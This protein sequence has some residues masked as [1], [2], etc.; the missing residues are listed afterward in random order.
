MPQIELSNHTQNSEI[1]KVIIEFNDKTNDSHVFWHDRREQ[2]LPTTDFLKT[3]HSAFSHPLLKQKIFFDGKECFFYYQDINSLKHF[4]AAIYASF[5]FHAPTIN[6]V[7]IIAKNY[8]RSS[9]QKT[10]PYALRNKGHTSLSIYQF[11]DLIKG[12]ELGSNYHFYEKLCFA[13]TIYID[14]LPESNIDTNL[15]KSEIDLPSLTETLIEPIY[16]NYISDTIGHGAFANKRIKQGEII[17]FYAGKL[18]SQKKAPRSCFKFGLSEKN[19]KLV[20]DAASNGNLSRFI[21]HAPLEK[22]LPTLKLN[23]KTKK[24]VALANV[25]VEYQC[26]FGLDI[27]CFSALRDIDKNEQLFID[28]G[29]KYWKNVEPLYFNRKNQVIN[30]KGEKQKNAQTISKSMLRHMAHLGV[31]EANKQ[32]YLKPVIAFVFFM[33]IFLLINLY[34]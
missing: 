19:F 22:K 31:Q 9:P 24:T 7:K 1:K 23:K 18:V 17:S 27:I 8:Q 34:L 12:H 4:A 28:Y 33:F 14:D 30:K 6:K 26:Y 10:I 16:I 25:G 32:L 5:I 21:N 29:A 13:K 2:K 20:V 11:E 15:K 3:Y